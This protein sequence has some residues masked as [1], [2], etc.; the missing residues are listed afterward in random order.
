MEEEDRDYFGDM[1]RYA[2]MAA[3]IFGSADAEQV[4]SDETKLQALLR[5]LQNVG[6]AANQVSVQARG[7]HPDIPWEDMIAMRHRLVHDYRRIRIDVVV[8][9]VRSDIPELIAVLQRAL[10]DGGGKP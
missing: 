2:E 5:A 4:I 8:K 3:R 10:D 9:T 7:R 6:E 1:L